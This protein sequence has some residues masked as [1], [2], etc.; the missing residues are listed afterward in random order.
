MYI[1]ATVYWGNVGRTH[2]D[3]QLGKLGSFAATSALCLLWTITMS[4]SASLSN[5]SAVREDVKFLDDL[6]EKYLDMIPLLEQLAPFLV[7]ICN[8]HKSGKRGG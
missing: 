5:A 2:N 1:I 3:F 8:S 4:F 7:V 6:F